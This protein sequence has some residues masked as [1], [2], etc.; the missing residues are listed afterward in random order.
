GVVSDSQLRELAS[1]FEI[2]AH[3]LNHVFLADADDATAAGE[4]SGS[5]KWVEDQTGRP[6][7]MF[8]PPAGKFTARHRPMFRDAGFAGIRTVEFMSYDLPRKCDG[9]M[10]MPTTLQAFPQPRVNYVRNLTKR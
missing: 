10:E 7:T 3:T 4:I 1:R 2:G 5:K 6:C 8:C 9:V